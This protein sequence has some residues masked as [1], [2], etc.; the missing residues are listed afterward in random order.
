MPCGYD[1]ART[2]EE[3]PLLTRLNKYGSLRAVKENEVYITDGNHYFNRPGPRLVDS[4]E[5][6]VEILHADELGKFGMEGTAWKSAEH[7]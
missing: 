1:L 7:R 6:L 4:L 3:I 2:R 5:I